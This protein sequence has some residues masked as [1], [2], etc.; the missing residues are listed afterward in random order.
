[1]L[2]HLCASA[3]WEASCGDDS[4][5]PESQRVRGGAHWGHWALARGQN[6][7]AA[8]EGNAHTVTL[9]L[10]SV[11]SFSAL[12]PQVF[13]NPL[14]SFEKKFKGFWKQTWIDM[15]L[16]KCLNLHILFKKRTWS[17]S[18]IFYLSCLHVSCGCIIVSWTTCLDKGW[19][20]LCAYLLCDWSRMMQVTATEW[21]S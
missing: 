15:D 18:D 21:E 16:W 20:L 2:F 4:Q 1:M 17:S 7:T 5:R 6:N 9:K 10:H 13:L 12:L 11:S 14:N 8:Q 3:E 19:W